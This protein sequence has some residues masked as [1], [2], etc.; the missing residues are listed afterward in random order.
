MQIHPFSGLGYLRWLETG[1]AITLAGYAYAASC[2]YRTPTSK[3]KDEEYQDRAA[4]LLHRIAVLR[5]VS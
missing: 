2:L 5:E 1:N 3:K 4:T